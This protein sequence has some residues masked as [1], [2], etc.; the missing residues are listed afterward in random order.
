MRMLKKAALNT[1][2][3]EE[4]LFLIRKELELENSLHLLKLNWL[5]TICSG[6]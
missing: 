3:L 4:Q 1:T 2:G 6:N 5:G